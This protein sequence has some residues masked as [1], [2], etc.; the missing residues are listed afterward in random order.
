MVEKEGLGC[1]DNVK[2]LQ[3]EDEE[4]FTSLVS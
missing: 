1:V 3:K 2:E 4:L